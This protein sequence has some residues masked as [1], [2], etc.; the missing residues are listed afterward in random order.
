MNQHTFT[1]TVK[2]TETIVE[3]LPP[4]RFL[5]F[6][7]VLK[8][9]DLFLYAHAKSHPIEYVNIGTSVMRSEE[10]NK[11]WY[12]PDAYHELELVTEFEKPKKASKYRELGPT[13]IIQEN[14]QYYYEPTRGWRYVTKSVGFLVSVWPGL[15]DNPNP[16]RRFRRKL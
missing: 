8:A 11:I 14:D 5:K 3:N 10:S 1:R 7:D 6:G 13:E 15:T 2:K 9:G 16:G 12:R 4:G